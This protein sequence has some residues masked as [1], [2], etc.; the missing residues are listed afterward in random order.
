MSP[1]ALLGRI[2]TLTVCRLGS[3]GAFL[4]VDPADARPGAP[5][6]LLPA[7]EVPK[8]AEV[9]SSIDVFVA[10]DSERRLIATTRAPRLTLG[11]VAFLRVTDVT[12]VG[13]FVDWGLG[14]EL[15]VP[16][17]E[18]T[19][20]LFVG[21]RH[22]IG[23]YIDESGRLAGTM[24]VSELLRDKGEFSPEEWVDGE[25]WRRDPE[26]GV[27]VIVE[28]RFVGRLPATE[29]H[30]LARGEAA[31]FRVANVLPDGNIELS[32]RGRAHDELHADAERIV[33][34]L[35]RAHAPR[36]GDRSSPE[37]IRAAFG[38]SKKAFKRAAGR[39]LKDGRIRADAAGHF[40]LQPR[41]P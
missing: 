37:D 10:L 2:V 38:L 5:T 19:R 24:R 31:R 21:D 17:A 18:Q 28:R 26:L 32:L 23:L 11:E 29:P 15:L 40:V 9:G 20:A 7:S 35:G 8:G 1:D 22:A 33:T 25:A 12:A 41:E 39:L 6:L 27:F 4:A 14:K 16:F 36:I 34:E 3:P 30:A 13:A